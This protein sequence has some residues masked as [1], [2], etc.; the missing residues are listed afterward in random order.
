MHTLL[1]IM[2]RFD[3]FQ[4]VCL[5]HFILHTTKTHTLAFVFLDGEFTLLL[6]CTILEMHI[7]DIFLQKVSYLGF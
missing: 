7:M 5:L 1:V 2:M 6:Q 4:K 3:L